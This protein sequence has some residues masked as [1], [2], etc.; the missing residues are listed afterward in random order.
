MCISKIGLI[1][2]GL[3]MSI[4]MH[5]V[6][7]VSM[8]FMCYFSFR[9]SYNVSTMLWVVFWNNKAR[10]IRVFVLCKLCLTTRHNFAPFH[11]LTTTASK[12]CNQKPLSS[13]INLQAYEIVAK[14]ICKSYSLHYFLQSHIDARLTNTA[15]IFIASRWFVSSAI[16]K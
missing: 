13:Y 14:V 10:I 9:L 2:Y 12:T 8:H 7:C 15:A 6:F 3:S 4:E 1:D 5:K 16:V 11:P